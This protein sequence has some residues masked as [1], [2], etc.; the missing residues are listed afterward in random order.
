MAAS[1]YGGYFSL[2]GT[3]AG[4][5]MPVRVDGKMDGI[6]TQS[7]SG[8][9]RVRGWK[10]METGANSYH[11]YCTPN[12]QENSVKYVSV[13]NSKPTPVYKSVEKTHVCSC[14]KSDPSELEMFCKDLH[15]LFFKVKTWLDKVLIWRA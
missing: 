8:R 15:Q 7:N 5:R 1:C 12:L 4:T 2:A 11:K 10:R 3:L 9:K 13:S 14:I 6:K